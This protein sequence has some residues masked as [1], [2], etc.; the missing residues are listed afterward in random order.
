MADD[1]DLDSLA[2]GTPGFS[3]AD[4]E[5]LLNEA[6]LLAAREERE[7]IK[8]Q[9]IEQARDK[10]L[11]GLERRG[12][13]V[14]DEE[15]RIIA[16]HETGH[17]LTAALLPNADP[18]HKV[19]IVPRTQ[20]MGVTQQLPEREK[21]I[22]RREYMLD[23]LAVMMGGRVAEQI[24]FGTSTSGAGNDLQEATKLARQMVLEWGMTDKFRN[25]ALGDERKNVFLGE[26][27][28][29]G[30]NYSE[31]TAREV[32]E[33]VKAI[34]TDAY[35]RTADLVNEHRSKMDEIVE[36]L[37][38][39]EEINGS[40]V[41]EILGLDPAEAKPEDKKS[42]TEDDGSGRDESSPETGESKSENH[43]QEE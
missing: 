27:L 15:Q 28:S 42:E 34:L 39:H 38:E 11:M 4:L 31:T 5:N 18:V 19:S 36:V 40:R 2:R 25:M 26:E 9:D 23:R 13:A 1:V 12:L 16:Y 21:Y 17:A 24:V 14:T 29:H 3:G 6:A 10:V 20:S 43:R 22:Y 8:N 33:E 7:E 35:N 30:R 41:L 37:L 32:D